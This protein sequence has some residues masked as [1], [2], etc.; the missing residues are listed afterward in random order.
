MTE[1]E[2]ALE[3]AAERIYMLHPFYESGEYVDTFQISPGGY[4]SWEEAKRRDAEFGD[5]PHMGN[6]TEFAYKAAEAALLSL[7]AML[8]NAQTQ[9]T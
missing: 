9:N 8:C 6:I 5:D 1:R 4:L 2:K 7:E 3:A